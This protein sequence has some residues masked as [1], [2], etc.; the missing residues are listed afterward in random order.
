MFRSQ[1]RHFESR[2]RMA[3][4]ADT[5]EGRGKGEKFFSSPTQRSPTRIALVQNLNYLISYYGF[6]RFGKSIKFDPIVTFT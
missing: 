6:A 3:Q 2:A 4:E 5:G 1:M